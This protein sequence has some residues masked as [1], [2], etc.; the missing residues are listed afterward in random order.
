V[1]FRRAGSLEADS[2]AAES[3]ASLASSRKHCRC[4][5]KQI[6][7]QVRKHVRAQSSTLPPYPAC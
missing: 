5:Q 4:T 3:E 1:H 6:D 7:M 2:A